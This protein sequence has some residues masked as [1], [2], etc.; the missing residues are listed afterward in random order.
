MVIKIF[1]N[2]MK[3]SSGK[4]KKIIVFALYDFLLRDRLFL[5]TNSNFANTSLEKFEEFLTNTSFIELAIEYNVNYQ[6]WH[7]ILKGFVRK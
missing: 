2:F 7:E 5:Q 3:K 1:L 4:R 6:K